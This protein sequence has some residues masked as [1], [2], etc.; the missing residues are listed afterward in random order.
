MKTLFKISLV[1]FLFTSMIACKNKGQEA[2]EAGDVAAATGQNY[3]VDAAASKVLWVGSKPTGTHNGTIA[4]NEGT[5]SVENGMVTAGA[6]TIDMNSISVDDLEGDYKAD[7]EKHLKGTGKEGQEDFFNVG[8]YP[9]AKFEVTKV[10]GLA[11]DTTG[12]ALVYGNLTL[13]DVTKEV[14]FKANINVAETEVTVDAPA[15]EI[16]RTDWGIKYGSKS[17]FDNLKDK[18]IDDAVKIAINLKASAAPAQ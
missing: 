9:T 18:F 4:V 13:L 11:N 8:K 17:F 14:S 5:V 2:G 1:L 12:N 16:N 3:T 7:L 10:T 15:F 6:F